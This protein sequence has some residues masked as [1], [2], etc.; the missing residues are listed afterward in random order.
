[1]AG[2]VDDDSGVVGLRLV[3]INPQ[4]PD[5]AANQ[6]SFLDTDSAGWSTL[7]TDADGNKVWD[8]PLGTEIINGSGR[9][10]RS[11]SQAL[12]VFS[13]LGAGPTVPLGTHVFILR[14]VDANGRA[15]TLKHVTRGDVTPPVLTVAQVTVRHVDLTQQT[16]TITSSLLLPNFS[17][18]DEVRISGLWSDDSTG[19]WA[20][21]NLIG[22]IEAIWGTTPL[23]ATRNADGTWSTAWITPP[24][25]AVAQ[26]SAT[27]RDYGGNQTTQNVS[28]FVETDAPQLLLISSSNEDGY[29]NAGDVIDIFLSFNK[30]VTFSGGPSPTL[31]L[32]NGRSATYTGG[33]G[34]AKHS[35]SYTVQA[36]DT[37]ADLDVS[38]IVAN[39]NVWRDTAAKAAT[40]TMPSGVNSLAGGKALVV[41]TAAPTLQAL[42][43]V[44]PSGAYNA[45]KQVFITA[46]FSEAVTVSGSPTLT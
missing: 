26:I 4:S 5:A 40:M 12:S 39:G 41:D 43:S 3:W 16:Y 37:A 8:V 34:T 30:K 10:E 24:G 42:S 35:F 32:S 29:Y 7:G 23:S 31:H 28:F 22:S 6:I 38:D 9:R 11:F 33:N 44:T 13:D 17:A 18:G 25:G 2:T 21:K 14:A 45:G 15:R 19:V 20:N 36:G 46:T 1:M 27:I